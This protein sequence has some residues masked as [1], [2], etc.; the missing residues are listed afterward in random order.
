MKHVAKAEPLRSKGCGRA[1][2]FPCSTGW[3]KCEKNGAG[4][5]IVC[6]TCQEAGK[7]TVYEGETGR[8]GFT[9]GSEHLDALRLE[10]G[11]NALWKY[12]QVD[13]NGERAEF[14][15]TSLKI[16]RTALVRQINK[17]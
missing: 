17:A 13:H 5:R 3:G 6:L 7:C 14:S 16:H 4:S 11:E 2:C 9:R 1:E 8:N 15:M 10:D 12:C